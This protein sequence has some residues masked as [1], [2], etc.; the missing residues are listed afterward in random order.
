M[1]M[2]NFSETMDA[3][4]AGL[5]EAEKARH[6]GLGYTFPSDTVYWD[7][8]GRKFAYINFRSVPGGFS[9]GAWLVEKATGEI[10]NI[11]GFGVPDYNKKKK[12]DIGNIATVDAKVMH[13]KRY[14]YL[15]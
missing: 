8:R 11:K 3:L 1:T 14:N 7:A 10:F 13:S 9:S 4:V 5:N 15:R 2:E 6:E 12:A